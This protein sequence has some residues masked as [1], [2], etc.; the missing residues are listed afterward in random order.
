M[1]PTSKTETLPVRSVVRC[2]TVTQGI[3]S[4]IKEQKRILGP[5]PDPNFYLVQETA[6]IS[7]S[8]GRKQKRLPLLSLSS[9]IVLVQKCTT[10]KQLIR[11]ITR[12]R[13]KNSAPCYGGNFSCHSEQYYQSNTMTNHYIL[14]FLECKL[15]P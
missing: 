11:L 14:H 7:A 6:P 1:T 12:D 10:T 2:E 4:T 13:A 8:T 3:K 9:E 5:T 15:F